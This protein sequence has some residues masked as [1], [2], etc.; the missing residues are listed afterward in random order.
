MNRSLKRLILW[1]QEEKR[2]FPWRENP[3]PYS[4]WVSEVMLQQTRASVV[5]PYFLS[6]MQKFPSIRSLAEAPRDEVIKAWE[7]LGYYSRARNLHDGAQY[8]VQHFD[9]ELPCCQEKLKQIK[10]LGP[11]TIGAIRSFAFHEK[12]A[13][14]DGNVIRVLCRLHAIEEDI[15]KPKT[16]ATIREEAEKLLPEHEPWVVNE[17]LIE[18]G[19]TLCNKSA[20]CRICPL[21][22]S[23]KAYSTGKVEQLPFKSK[24]IKIKPLYRTVFVIQYEDQFLIRKGKEGEIMAD[25][26]EF[27]FL[28][29]V[30]SDPQ[31]LQ[32]H[33]H[34]QWRIDL[35]FE[36]ELPK[37]THTFTRYKAHLSP[38]LFTCKKKIEVAD[39]EWKS[40][41]EMQF[42]P[43]SSGHRKIYQCITGPLH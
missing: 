16:V 23:C 11:Y 22:E 13:A 6:W 36:T 7:G 14:V 34:K 4:V 20:Q 15:A 33:L 37:V 32:N 26:H 10:G 28:E 21:R 18:L 5:V 2:S 8:V 30:F 25:L 27:P 24:K 43:F 41:E 42:L 17:A 3:T 38:I 12:A 29:Q 19:A 35:S 1:F 40:L 9:G 39:L 31:E